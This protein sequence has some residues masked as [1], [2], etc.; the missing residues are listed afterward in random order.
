MSGDIETNPGP[1]YKLCPQ[2]D[3]YI[4]ILRKKFVYVVTFFAKHLEPSQ[5]LPYSVSIVNADAWSPDITPDL[6]QT[7]AASLSTSS[8]DVTNTSLDPST[9]FELLNDLAHDVNS[10]IIVGEKLNDT[11]SAAKTKQI[12]IHQLKTQEYEGSAK[13]AKRSAVVNAQWW[14]KYKFDQIGKRLSNRKYYYYSQPTIR[15][16][17]ILCAYHLNPLPARKRMWDAYHANPS[18]IKR[19]ARDAYHAHPWAHTMSMKLSCQ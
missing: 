18:P 13:W 4:S 17:Q 14:L 12:E 6:T 16:K 1:I 11:P 15:S 9:S 8:T 3:R 10:R 2:C 7:T 5:R 19:K